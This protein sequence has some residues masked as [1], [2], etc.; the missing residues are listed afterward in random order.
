M[1][2]LKQYESNKKRIAA[3]ALHS[4]FLFDSITW[5]FEEMIFMN[6]MTKVALVMTA[7]FLS[8]GVE[9]SCAGNGNRKEVDRL[10]K[11]Y[12]KASENDLPQKGTEILGKIKDK[13]RA[14]KLSY[15]FWRAATQYVSVSSQRDWKRRVELNDA[16]KTEFRAYGDPIILYISGT[17][18]NRDDASECAA[19]LEKWARKLKSSQ[20]EDFWDNSPV[21]YKGE[22]LRSHIR[23]DYEYVLLSMAF[24]R[25][26][27]NSIGYEKIADKFN[28][29]YSE[30]Y[31]VFALHELYNIN[32]SSSKVY[33]E[34]AKKYEGKAVA[35][36]AKINALSLKFSEL[37]ERKA[38]EKEY[39]ELRKYCGS[40][41]AEKKK[42]SGK[43][44][45]ILKD[46]DAAENMIK[47]LDS[48]ELS[49]EIHGKDI[50]VHLQNL[51]DVN[52]S[53]YAGENLNVEKL[54]KK[55]VP[56]WTK[57]LENKAARYYVYDTL[58]VMLPELPDGDY[59]AVFESGKLR[60]DCNLSQHSVALSANRAAEGWL[61]Y[62]AE[63]KSGKP[64]D[65]ADLVVGSW[66]GKELLRK[67]VRFNGATLMDSDVQSV[68]KGVG[69]RCWLQCSLTDVQGLERSSEKLGLY[70][71]E[72][73]VSQSEVD[74]QA[75][76]LTDRS[77]YRPGETIHFKTIL[78]KDYRNGRMSTAPSEEKV[79]V[80]LADAENKDVQ[81]V[82]LTTSDFGS[83]A[84]TFTIPGDRRNGEWRIAVFVGGYTVNA[85]WFTV[86]EF[87]LPE[88]SVSFV[89]DGVKY[90]PGD[91]VPVKGRVFSYAGNSLSDARVEY[92]V[93]DWNGVVDKGTPELD[94]AGNF[95]IPVRT[96]FDKESYFTVTM[97]ITDG[98][99]QTLEFS[100]WL[101]VGERFGIEAELID[102]ADG[103]FLRPDTSEKVRFSSFRHSHPIT[104]SGILKGDA[105]EFAVELADCDGEHL[106]GEI[107]W[108][109]K[110]GSTELQ[111]GRCVSGK[112]LKID[113]SGEPSGV[114]TVEFSK[115][116]E[117][118]GAGG[119]KESRTETLEYELL[120]LCDNET[121]LDADVENAFKAIESSDGN[122]SLLFGASQGDIWA[123]IMIFSL[124]SHL[125]HNEKLHLDGIR[126]K[127]GSLKMLSWKHAAEWSDK[128][129]LRIEYFRNGLYRTFEHE[130]QRSR[131]TF[132]LPLSVSTFT[133]KCLPGAEYRVRLH[134]G[135]SVEVL[136]AVSDKSTEDI[137]P[138]PWSAVLPAFCSI[139][140]DSYNGAGCEFDGWAG[141]FGHHWRFDGGSNR[142]MA[143]AAMAPEAADATLSESA[144]EKE[145]VP[146]QLVEEEPGFSD[147]S[148]S[149][150]PTKVRK[151]FQ[152]TLA[153]EP[154]LQSDENGNVEFR[155]RTSDRLSTYIL[156]LFAH[157]KAFRNA[158]L[159]KE[160]IVSQ[161]VTI[162]IHEPSLLYGGDRYIFRPALSNNS[163]KDI[164]GTL[165]VYV[166][167][168]D[169]DS[170]PLSVQNCP[171]SVAAGKSV[172]KD[173][174]VFAPETSA[175]KSYDRT[176]ARLSIKATFAGTS[177]A[178]GNKGT[179]FS[180]AVLVTIPILDGK[181]VLTESHS[182]IFRHGTDREALI[183]SLESQFVNTSHFGA[184]T[185]E[186]KI[187][188]LVAETLSQKT[189]LKSKNLLD[190]SEVLYVLLVSEKPDTQE[191]ASIV[192]SLLDCRCEDGGFAWFAGM[193]S[194][195]IL[196]SV[197][198]ERLALLR[199]EG[200][201][202]EGT[203]WEN[204]LT[205]AVKYIDRQMFIERNGYHW[206]NGI[207]IGQYLYVR[208][209]F[210]GLAIDTKTIKADVGDKRFKE[211]V[212]SMKAYLCPSAK[213]DALN[214]QILEKARRSSTI[215]NLIS[216]SSDAFDSSIGL[217]CRKM[218]K[219]LA[220]SVESLKEYA[221]EHPSGGTYYP[222]AVM[223]FRALLSSE[224]YAHS[225]LCDMFFHWSA[226]SE[227]TSGK[228]DARAQEIADGIRLWLMVQKES[229]QW[230]NH[231]ESFCAINSIRRGSLA[232]LETSIISLSKTY[233]KSFEEIKA[234]G[235]GFGIKRQFLV[236]EL[237]PSTVKGQE[238]TKPSKLRELKAGETLSVG[239]KIVVRYSISSDENRC[240]VHVRTPY[241]ACLRPIRQLSGNYGYAL[242]IW[243]INGA[244][245]GF[246]AWWITPQGYR[247]VRDSVIDYW[248]DVYPEHNTTIEDEF[249][250]SQAGVFT[251]PVC[252]IESLYAPHYRA[253]SA[254]DGS[255][256]VKE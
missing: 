239:Q 88:F 193:S 105:A 201:L 51:G 150:D 184:V 115:T 195:P 219:V 223:P 243:R 161:P 21:S 7:C 100:A 128:V 146:F 136:A 89:R 109:L 75:Q 15:D 41:V 43:E 118:T 123:N 231:F 61:L 22:V 222:N 1:S 48:K 13:A 170:Q 255:L 190:V 78:Y 253:N 45:L 252:E 152:S 173:F 228:P 81:T 159:R 134:T 47:T 160:F 101:R 148:E 213:E 210:P 17:D 42:F 96:A 4:I 37:E 238:G 34:Y 95:C 29:T 230:Q 94:E 116:Y 52:I 183:H 72:D 111:K 204:V 36:L 93:S 90:F 206:F 32:A 251:A 212:K 155:F 169:T 28:S 167:D 197:L 103:S 84:G 64:V 171:V 54:T 233:E 162:T 163:G 194:S 158:T 186:T 9:A 237:V 83:V 240:L 138:N 38:G 208:S 30:T 114:Y 172:N 23:N 211:V 165:T 249:Y 53:I 31:P 35:T 234:A 120:K 178:G 102:A 80:T 248:F 214:R 27:S 98:A 177:S 49:A 226:W 140:V 235:N 2:Y 132:E 10:W 12:E 229:Q 224:A 56:V 126:G 66:N 25:S 156:A 137:R 256:T 168:G 127:A 192:K 203:D 20:S 135:K 46:E 97:K 199:E 125:L 164:S 14:E 63:R 68:L 189:E 106:D 216:S 24:N 19:F 246:N 244:A 149:A 119:G 141:D 144:A 11:E 130:Y 50:E 76:V 175:M 227:K 121:S 87:K 99:G 112:N 26:L 188:E 153:F 70:T 71:P 107:E 74:W 202:P 179:K 18:C 182:A 147:G 220:R 142:L 8:V 221:V 236:E 241:N 108:V 133:D 215:L 60:H 245:R 187:S 250:V 185:R 174:S 139:Y 92:A 113:L 254:S 44:G 242:R 57:N 176:K 145:A 180:D 6:M 5:Y 131:A 198:L 110:A 191:V 16:M 104:R 91:V 40:L 154:F 65:E 122:I 85:R 247:E 217:K 67:K 33:A 207:S 232:L 225:L 166:Y 196:T 151:N 3:F 143:K 39:R 77:A 82:E 209:F 129:M 58:K 205:D 218:K 86:D 200:R 181:Q 59:L 157:D 69:G 79:R 117:Y 62:A 124:D 73:N 55:D